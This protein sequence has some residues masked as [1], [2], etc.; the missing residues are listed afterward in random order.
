MMCDIEFSIGESLGDMHCRCVGDLLRKGLGCLSYKS[1]KT[2]GLEVKEGMQLDSSCL[3]NFI[4]ESTG[5]PYCN[6]ELVVIG[7]EGDGLVVAYSYDGCQG[8]ILKLAYP[9]KEDK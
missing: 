9:D 8:G 1:P 6:K 4:E 3:K 7:E 5:K 2:A